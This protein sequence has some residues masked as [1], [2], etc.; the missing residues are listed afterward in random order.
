MTD[1]TDIRKPAWL[2]PFAI[3]LVAYYLGMAIVGLLVP[4]DILKGNAWARAFCDF[5]ATIVPQIDRITALGV[6]PDV[7]RFYFSALWAGSPM[8]FLIGLLHIW[9]GRKLGFPIWTMPF[10]RSCVYV[11]GL[12][13][14][15]LWTQC[16]WSVYP[17]MRLT[18]ALFLSDVGRSFYAQA[19]LYVMPVFIA[20]GITA[21][22]IGWLTGY[23]PQNI[24]K[25][26]H[27]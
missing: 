5:M 13:L 23:I 3:A 22:L 26:R 15:A 17:D 7:N 12:A 1:P 8:A 24:E 6:E 20:A 18:K 2:D 19:V 27:G 10:Y 25:Q 9:N 4:D 14:M 21:S 16:L 11:I